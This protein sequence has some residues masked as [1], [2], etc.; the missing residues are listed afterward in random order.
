VNINITSL[1]V[2]LVQTTCVVIVFAYIL[3]RT[4]LIT[5]VLDRKIDIKYQAILILI[6]GLLSIYG[7]YG[8]IQLNS[9]VIANIRDLG[10]MLAGLIGGPIVGLGAGLI[11]GIHRYL[12]GGFVCVPCG[13]SS[14]L[15]GLFGGLIYL[16]KRE[17]LSEYGRP[18][19]LP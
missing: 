10:P 4:S 16:L 9:G 19:C 18:Q 15:A 11:G 13:L 5:K 6:F 14:V 2:G 1:F 12:L 8:G 7:T 17:E 3:T